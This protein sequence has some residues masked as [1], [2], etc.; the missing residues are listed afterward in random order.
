M[1]KGAATETLLGELH[2]L[3]AQEMISKIRQAGET[4]EPLPSSFLAVVIKFLNDNGIKADAELS[5]DIKSL[6]R[7]LPTL[8]DVD[9]DQYTQQ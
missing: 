4:G 6:A 7:S 5:E 2:N 3:T 1:A 8:E 9:H